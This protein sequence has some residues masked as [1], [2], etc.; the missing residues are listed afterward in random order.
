[1]I[2]KN[3][4]SE[5]IHITNTTRAS[6]REGRTATRKITRDEGR[7]I[8]RKEMGHMAQSAVSAQSVRA[9]RARGQTAESSQQP[10]EL[11]FEN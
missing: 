4:N 8:G 2:R 7:R 9:E 10:R 3:D 1:M 11:N 5:N 6:E